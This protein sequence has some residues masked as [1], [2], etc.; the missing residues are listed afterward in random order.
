MDDKEL[1]D[2]VEQELFY[3]MLNGV[4]TL[5]HLGY[6]EFESGSWSVRLR[7]DQIARLLDMS[8]GKNK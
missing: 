5:D 7:A 1:L 2:Y 4:A 8:K 6:T 3:A